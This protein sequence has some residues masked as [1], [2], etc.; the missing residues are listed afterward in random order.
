[1]C[2]VY[3]R[4]VSLLWLNVFLLFEHCCIYFYHSNKTCTS[5]M[6]EHESVVSVWSELLV[7]FEPFLVNSNLGERICC[8]VTRVNTFL[9][10]WNHKTRNQKGIMATYLLAYLGYQEWKSSE[11]TDDDSTE[12][13]IDQNSNKCEIILDSLRKVNKK[14][15]LII[16]TLLTIILS[17]MLVRR[18]MKIRKRRRDRNHVTDKSYNSNC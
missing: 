3:C 7:L 9:L 13:V 15:L 2:G 6:V 18:F 17:L 5:E 8:T 14:L 12:R 4:I 1:M 10:V 16:L 11:I